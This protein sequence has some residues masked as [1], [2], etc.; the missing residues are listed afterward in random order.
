MT[1]I[2]KL[3]RLS[4]ESEKPPFPK[5]S[6]SV[7]DFSIVFKPSSCNEV[8]SPCSSDY[9]YH[10]H[11]K[12]LTINGLM[13]LSIPLFINRIAL[14]LLSL[15]NKS[16][17]LN[18][19][20]FSNESWSEF[21]EFSNERKQLCN[22]PLIN[23]INQTTTTN[24]DEFREV[25]IDCPLVNNSNL[26]NRSKS[27]NDLQEDLENQIQ[28]EK[29]NFYFIYDSD[30]SKGNV[31]DYN[32]L[33][34]T[35]YSN[36][37]LSNRNT[38][39]STILE[40]SSLSLTK[41]SAHA[42]KYKNSEGVKRIQEML[43]D[44]QLKIQMM[45]EIIRVFEPSSEHGLFKRNI[46]VRLTSE[47]KLAASHKSPTNSIVPSSS[48]SSSGKNASSSDY[49]KYSPISYKKAYEQPTIDNVIFLNLNQINARMNKSY[50]SN[51]NDHK[52]N[53]RLIERIKHNIENIKGIP[54]SKIPKENQNFKKTFKAQSIQSI[55][56]ALQDDNDDFKKIDGGHCRM[57]RS[58][59]QIITKSNIQPAFF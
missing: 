6:Y 7:P 33:R 50:N 2:N 38:S 10:F 40:E 28:Q 5:D 56:N 19:N 15:I 4:Q 53:E 39:L 34:R 46:P 35:H 22:S 14:L 24:Y 32:S 23:E 8:P 12:L 43:N 58:S 21:V 9:N 42:E 16:S 36:R 47:S 1:A 3:V 49:S 29:N 41:L 18:T 11:A 30:L 20:E 45:N 25:P 55:T 57:K 48:P 44:F 27:L 51:D 13:L 26:L 52:R 59:S 54:L 37:Y 31:C 17:K